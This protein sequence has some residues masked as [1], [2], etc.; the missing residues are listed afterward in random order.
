MTFIDGTAVNVVLP[1][2]DEA[3]DAG[4]SA[5]QWIVEAY[6]LLL[7]SLMLLGGSLGDRYGRRRL[8]VAGTMAF[9]LA[10]AWCG[11]SDT[12]AHLVAARA[13]QGAGAALLVPGSLAIISASFSERE[14]GAAIGSWAAGT[15]IAAGAG[16]VVGGWLVEH[17]SWRWVFFINL[18]LAVVT[19]WIALSRLPDDHPSPGGTRLDWPGAVLATLGL[20]ALVFGLV[21]AGDNGADSLATSA[22]ASG[23]ACIAAFLVLE[24]RLERTS[25][26][27]AA[28][29]PLSLF[30]SPAFA[31]TNLL[32]VF[33]YAALGMVIFVLPF[34]LIERHGYSVVAA[35]GALVP[36]VLVMF[37][38][39]RWAGRLLDRR[40]PRLP[41]IAGPLVT[42][43]G[44]L[45]MMRVMADGNYLT[46]VLPAVLT[47]SLGM[48]ITVA[49]LTA[50][51]MTA[52]DDR[53]AGLASGVNNAISRLA[54][55]LAVA[56]VGVLAPGTFATALTRAALVAAG[57]SVLGAIA[58]AAIVRPARAAAH[59]P[60]RLR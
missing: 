41:L 19:I 2:L 36:F 59:H 5:L 3:L 48:V 15:S 33:L 42:A 46:G 35:S 26:V 52:V 22:I 14:R 53:H 20:G 57:L 4:P 47:M 31:G 55:L 37:A 12:A 30:S 39:S 44:H 49:P 24:R 54:S 10:S 16:P 25:G 45:L 50:T 23:L 21:H 29:M 58:A 9:A 27:E 34:T 17:L 8:F 40:G 28:M 7:T 51:V 38:L 13:L 32:T 43:A 1:I 60:G 11:L 6:L 56:L 18:P